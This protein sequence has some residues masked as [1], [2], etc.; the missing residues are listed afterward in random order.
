MR[1]GPPHRRLRQDTHDGV[2]L[3][4]AASWAATLGERHGAR[5]R[6]ATLAA[7]ATRDAA[8]DSVTVAL[9]RW[10]RIVEAMT[11]LVDAYNTAFESEVLD[12]AEDR[13][14]TSRPVVTIRAAGAGDQSLVVTLE[15]SV[16]CARRSHSGVASCETAYDLRADRGDDET[17]AYVLQHWMEHL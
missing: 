11:L 13:S 10:P 6:A 17:A 1:A 7:R 16:I 9:L 8:A 15:D 5:A 14:V 12:I 2:A 3:L 4:M